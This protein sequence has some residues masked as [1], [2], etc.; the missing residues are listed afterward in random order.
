MT[1]RTRLGLAAGA[2]ALALLGTVA[3]ALAPRAEAAVTADTPRSATQDDKVQAAQEIGVVASPDLLILTDR[4]FVFA[5]WQRATGTEVR[6][7]AE[8]AYAGTQPEWTQWIKT[9]VR[10]ANAR[11]QARILR[12][13]AAARAAREAKQRAALVNKIEPSQVLLI[14]SDQEFAFAMWEHASGP[15][16]KAAALAAYQGDAAAQKNFILTG[17]FTARAA[18]LQDLIDADTTK[19]AEQKAADA[20]RDARILAA[21]V[22]AIEPTAGQLVEPDVNFVLDLWQ[23]A[24]AGTEV[25]AAAER[26]LRTMDTAQLRAYIGTGI[27][28][29][30]L[31]D[32]F[33]WIR[34]KGEADRR[35]LFELRTRAE[36]S[37]VHPALVAGANAAMAGTDNDVEQ[38]L[39]LG[40]YEDAALV[41]SLRSQSP[42]APGW[43]LRGL[44]DAVVGAGAG[45][46]TAWRVVPG[47]A[48]ASCHSFES[49]AHPEY[50]LRQQGLRVV[51]AASDGTDGFHADATWCSKAGL[52]G[53]GVTLE[54]YS[55]RGRFLRQYTTQVWA[56][57][58]GGSHPYDSPNG[59]AA[60]ASWQA[61]VP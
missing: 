29:A 41:Q 54:S 30:N 61:D 40:Q 11:D 49:V 12:D 58:T 59:Y 39:R 16:L 35:L 18:D 7:S 26:A 36:Q 51:L 22:V 43:Y 5:L 47:K 8:L 37:R 23:A 19:S 9:G 55:A 10:D 46:D 60:D 25:R 2:A 34:K 52:S 21:A 38:F 27:H 4:N 33:T 28:S 53:T 50:Y 3:P 57:D 45:T 32:W 17:I 6:A 44:T 20:A 42:G 14:Q 48:D 31:Q 56:A 1:G 24:K 13:D 15:K